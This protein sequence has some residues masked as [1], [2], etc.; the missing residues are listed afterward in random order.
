MGGRTSTHS[1]TPRAWA[2][3]RL[4]V[5]PPVYFAG[6]RCGRACLAKLYRLFQ[7][8]AYVPSLEDPS[9]DTRCAK[10]LTA[11]LC[12][13][14]AAAKAFREAFVR[15]RERRPC[16]RICASLRCL[17]HCS[18]STCLCASTCSRAK[19]KEVPGKVSWGFGS[20]FIFFG[21][22]KAIG[23]IRY[24]GAPHRMCAGVLV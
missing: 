12:R 10:V 23:A 9:S 5:D 24:T 1:G 8:W 16:T 21:C 14:H 4:G 22:W 2:S 15:V 20:H 13:R 19:P 18:M 11:L 17:R 6:R 3:E 7:R